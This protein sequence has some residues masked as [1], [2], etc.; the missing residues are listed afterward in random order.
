MQQ[1]V[2][3]L[4]AISKELTTIQVGLQQ[5]NENLSAQQGQVGTLSDSINQLA[6]GVNSANDGLT[7]IS[8][9]LTKATDI[10]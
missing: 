1:A 4:A 5:A 10:T 9:G 8:G 3:Q 6:K 7:K 2:P